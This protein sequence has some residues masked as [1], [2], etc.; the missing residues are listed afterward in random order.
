MDRSAWIQI[1]L[2]VLFADFVIAVFHWYE[3]RYLSW[4]DKSGILGQI[5]RENEMHHHIPFSIT[6][7][8]LWE[9]ARIPT[10]IALLFGALV[11]A[12]APAWSRSHVPFLATAVAIGS[13]GNVIHRYTHER[14]CNRPHVITLLQRI[15]IIISPEQHAA[16][17]RQ[18]DQKYGS[19]LS[20]TNVVYDSLGVWRALETV[21]P[22]EPRAQVSVLDHVARYDQKM[23]DNVAKPCPDTISRADLAKY[24]QKLDEYRATRRQIHQ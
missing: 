9:N 2:G 6:T 22:T 1:V 19:I 11:F 4:T 7:Y 12:A 16:H 20:F 10:F 18:P 5:A 17:H 21:M 3:D 24:T 15:G 13:V 23:K 14:E 8:T